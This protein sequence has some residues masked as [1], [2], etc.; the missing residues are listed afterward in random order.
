MVGALQVLRQL[1]L[2]SLLIDV[3]RIES[4]SADRI[5]LRLPVGG[6]ASR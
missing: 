5:I 6:L 4:G 1:S 3:L 2:K